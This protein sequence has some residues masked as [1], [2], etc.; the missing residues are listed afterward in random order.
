MWPSF[1]AVRLLTRRE[2]ALVAAVR[3][4]ALNASMRLAVLSA[5]VASHLDVVLGATPGLHLIESIFVSM[6]CNWPRQRTARRITDWIPTSVA[7]I[8][9]LFTSSTLRSAM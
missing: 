8:D 3:E 7:A 9:K 5:L 1:S 6:V 4:L 2:A